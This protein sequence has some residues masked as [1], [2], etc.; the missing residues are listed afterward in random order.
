MA[1]DDTEPAECKEEMCY[2]PVHKDGRCKCCYSVERNIM[3]WNENRTQ[4]KHFR[5][6]ERHAYERVAELLGLN[7]REKDQLQTL[8]CKQG[9]Y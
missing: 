2:H 7:W 9:L 6:G 4:M 1:D 5:D 8:V 3:E